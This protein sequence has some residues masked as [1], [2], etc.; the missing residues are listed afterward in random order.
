[1]YTYVVASVG[2]SNNHSSLHLELACPSILTSIHSTPPQTLHACSVL[3]VDALFAQASHRLFP[4][5]VLQ[6]YNLPV[7]AVWGPGAGPEVSNPSPAATGNRMI[8]SP[9]TTPRMT[10]T[11]Y[12]PAP[13]SAV[14]PGRRPRTVPSIPVPP[15]QSKPGSDVHASR[16]SAISP[17]KKPAVGANH[18]VPQAHGLLNSSTIMSPRTTPRFNVNINTSTSSFSGQGQRGE[19]RILSQQECTSMGVPMGSRI[20]TPATAFQKPQQASG[21]PPPPRTHAYKCIYKIASCTDD[22]LRRVTMLQMRTNFRN[23]SV[24][25]LSIAVSTLG[26][27]RLTVM[28]IIMILFTILNKCPPKGSN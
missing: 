4:F 9:A 13:S 19:G 6:R 1:M 15:A 24:Y 20:M 28:M 26:V 16:A 22:F 21:H 17:S 12:K 11:N 18:Q 27:K 10:S 14:S 2:E 23:L 3:I 5:S 8:S 7:G 25:S